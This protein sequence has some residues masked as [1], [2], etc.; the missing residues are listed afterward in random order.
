MIPKVL[1]KLPLRTVLILPFVLQIAGA[2]GL[3]GYLSFK[4]GQKAVN[5]L[6]DQLMSEMS[7]RVEQN[8]QVYLKT[9][10]QINQSKLDAVKLGMLKM[11]DLYPWEKYL[12]RQVQLY[13]YINFTSVTNVRGDYRSGEQMS[14]GLLIINAIEQSIRK[15]FYAYNTDKDGN[16]TSVATVVQFSDP[17]QHST[18]KEAVKSGK[19]TWSSVYVSFLEPTLIVSA[20]QPVYDDRARLEGVLSAALRLDHI[21]RFLNSL[22]IGK[23]G[24]AFIIDRQGT[25]LATSTSEKPFRTV[26]KERQLFKATESS[27]IFTQATAKYLQSQVA[28]FHQNSIQEEVLNFDINGKEQFLKVLPFQDGKGLNWSIVVVVPKADF[29][30]QIDANTRTAII[31]CLAALAVALIIGIMTSRWVTEPIVHLNA[32]AKNIAK[33]EWDKTEEISR[34]DE[35]G[36][37]GKSFNSMAKQLKLSFESLENRVRERTAELAVAKEKAEVANE[38]KSTFLANMSHELRSPLNAILG[39]CQ[40]TSRSRTLSP[41]DRENIS[42]ISRSGEY[43]LALI[44]NVLDLSKIEA[45]RT[46]LNSQKFDLYR[47]LCEVE[48]MFQLKADDKHLQLVFDRADMV[49]QYIATDELKL[50]Q[51]L[52][53]LLNNALKFTENGGVAVRVSLKETGEEVEVG[54]RAVKS[55]MLAG[56]SLNSCNAIESEGKGFTALTDGLDPARSCWIHFEVADTGAGI[57]EGELDNLFE[58]FVQTQ[59]G[60]A[61]QEG[62]GLGLPISRKFVELMGGKMSVVSEVGKGTIFKF[63]IQA[64]EVASA[65]NESK[66]TTRHPIALAP[67]RPSYRILIVDDKPI[68][69]QLLFKILNPLGFELKEAT[70]GQEAVKIWDSWEPHLIWMDMRMPV[71]DGYEATKQ[72][73]GTIKGQATAVIALTASVLEEERAVILSAGCDGFMRKP[74]REA[75]IFDVMHKHIGVR[76]IYEDPSPANLPA[77]EYSKQAEITAADFTLLPDLLV[78]NLRQGILNVDMDL[79]EGSIEQIRL[80]NEVLGGAIAN[81]IYNFEYDKVL[82]L[83]SQTAS[84]E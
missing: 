80:K 56:N 3:V 69:R 22:R 15:N 50:R 28:R 36:E 39:F 13:P 78:R 27:N 4:N 2:V 6:A 70:N 75:D 12:W 37:L 43:L 33:G 19:P 7:L 32:A 64:I 20:L 42:I 58:A 5:N 21:G 52:I 17:R 55:Q 46:T 59:T 8:L 24:Q 61:S 66:K 53:N 63:D 23:S 60:I 30:E 25:L 45:G 82:D 76:Y 49:P 79:I 14:N 62:T 73:K 74:F 18:Y 11:E 31:L 72:I 41:E 40:L 67:D 57:A 9:P 83:I 65:G 51:V 44:N 84:H 16:R 10:H 77:I 54:N 81:C 71:M 47:L 48:D 68:N 35:L 1:D 34:T 38:A 29:T 26:N